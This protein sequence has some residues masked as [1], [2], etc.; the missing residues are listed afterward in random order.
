M[1]DPDDHLVISRVLDASRARVW[2]AWT[3]SARFAKWWG[4][5]PFTLRVVKLDLKPGGIC[6]YVMQAPDGGDIWARFTYREAGPP[7]RLVFTSSF[8]DAG[9][10]VAPNPWIAD[11]PA[12]VLNFVTLIEEDGKTR[13]TLRATPLDASDLE[14]T[15]FFKMR[16]GM[17]H[18]LNGAFDQLAAYLAAGAD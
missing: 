10:E 4:S 17:Q 1:A 7:E 8:A 15:T 6:H 2:S 5:K 14:R 3:E 12:K 18:G 16:S 9:G 11:W 13:L